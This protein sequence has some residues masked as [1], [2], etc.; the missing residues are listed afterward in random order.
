MCVVVVGGDGQEDLALGHHMLL[1]GSSLVLLAVG[2]QGGQGGVGRNGRQVVRGREVAGN[3]CI[4]QAMRFKLRA[5]CKGSSRATHGQLRPPPSSS[6]LL[7]MDSVS[8]QHIYIPCPPTPCKRP[9]HTNI[10]LSHAPHPMHMSFKLSH[11][12][13]APHACTPTECS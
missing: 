3:A 9:M 11:A 2:R 10:Q 5:A 8:R 13:H 7:C 4:P 6:P 1:M 12:P